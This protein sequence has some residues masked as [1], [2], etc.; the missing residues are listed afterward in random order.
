MNETALG[1]TTTPANDGGALGIAVVT[2]AADRTLATDEAGEAIVSALEASGH[3]VATREHVS[4]EHD[5]VQSIVVRVIERDDVDI[6]IT[7]GSASVEPDDV[8]IEAVEPLLDKELTAFGEL[9]T[10]LAYEE[11]GTRAVAV[12]TLAGVA[13]GKPI[14]CLPGTAAGARLGAEELILP[15]ARHLVTL[16]YGPEEDGTDDAS[17]S[18]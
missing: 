17:D 3:D 9:Y 2:I 18:S 7:A 11:V 14:F 5:G 12:R 15:E 8:A 16:A 13:D 6:V 4:P 10:A 1:P